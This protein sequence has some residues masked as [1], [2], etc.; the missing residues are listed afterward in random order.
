[1]RFLQHVYGRVSRGYHGDTP[2]YQVAALSTELGQRA[3]VLQCLNRL[4]FYRFRARDGAGPTRY[5]FFRPA[6]DLLAVGQVRMTRDLTG[7]AASFA[8]HFVCEEAEF[9]RAKCSPVQL[10]RQLPFLGSESDLPEERALG[11]ILLPELAPE[12]TAESERP[13]ALAIVDRVF[14]G[15]RLRV[16]LL[17]IP[18][19]ELW[20]LLETFF[21]M[22]PRAE[23]ANVSFST[24]FEES[25]EFVDSFRLVTVPGE[26][27]ARRVPDVCEILNLEEP[28]CV[29]PGHELSAFW[30]R[31]PAH[32]EALSD[33]VNWLRHGFPPEG[34][35][36]VGALAQ[37]GREF[38]GVI[39][40]LGLTAIYPYLLADAA[41]LA[42][43]W[44]GGSPLPYSVFREAI[45]AQP[46]ERLP[47]VFAFTRRVN[48]SAFKEEA[49]LDVAR[50]LAAGTA[51]PDCFILVDRS[52]LKADFYRTCTSHLALGEIQVLSDRLA[53]LHGYDGELDRSVVDQLLDQEISERNSVIW[54]WV[55]H[56]PR[57]G[58]LGR[59]AVAVALGLSARPPALPWL[60]E[61]PLGI[62]DCEV[63]VPWA[64]SNAIRAGVQ[65]PA[66]VR[67]VFSPVS[68]EV[69]FRLLCD[70][71][72]TLDADAATACLL[73]VRTH[74]SFDERDEGRLIEIVDRHPNP[75][76]V[77]SRLVNILEHDQVGSS[78]L[79]DELREVI[80]RHGVGPW[81][82][83]WFKQ[84]GA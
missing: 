30:R 23:A 35:V 47:V 51:S 25:S 83:R 4:S 65:L 9:L 26:A 28:H 55:R 53:G 21:G 13:R 3:D 24:L 7:A 32:G 46:Q 70:R 16:P 8:H 44:Q 10:V 81:L 18:D 38:R 33:L 78:R 15:E 62:K 27:H 73:A 49:L 39:D 37:T 77:A 56:N 29:A 6:P 11:Q 54:E 68:R 74:P 79:R 48:A 12:H 17:V 14:A 80:R 75:R 69:V 5:S 67:G 61:F 57:C 66:A 58:R 50:Q 20:P 34:A 59:A 2:G 43:Y 84:G 1:V 52:G 63:L 41:D 31:H 40:R 60:G 82:G 71:T 45:W 36:G 64:W 76:R 19:G 42:A 22:L 72:N